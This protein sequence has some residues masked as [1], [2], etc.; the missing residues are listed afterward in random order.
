MSIK[1]FFKKAVRRLIRKI[2][3]C[4]RR[5]IVNKNHITL[6]EVFFNNF[7]PKCSFL[8][9]LNNKDHYI[10]ELNRLSVCSSIINSADKIC[11]HEFNLLGSGNK[12][13]GEKL[14]WNE[15]FKTWFKWNNKFYKDIKIVDLYNNADVKVPWELSRFQHLFTLGKAYWITNDENYALEF[16]EEVQHWIEKNPV[17]LSVNWACTMDAAIRAV[18]L[19]CGYFF[20]IESSSIDNNFRIKF[21][22]LLYTHGRFIY[23][24]LENEEENRNN[25]YLSDLAGLIW[26]GIFFENFNIKNS[27]KYNNPKH[28]LKFGLSEFENEMKKQVNEDG[29]DYEGS[30]AYHRL[31]T[32]IFLITT[33]LCNKNN[34]IFSKEYITKL[35]KMCEF[36]MNIDKPNGLS[37]IIGD[38]DDGRLLIL[39]NYGQWDRRDFTHVLAIAGEYFGRDDFRILGK[40]HGEDALWV[41]GS[42]KEICK[43]PELTSKAYH[44]GGYYILRNSRFY[45]IV[46]CGELSLRGEGGHSHNDQLSI[47]INVD[48]ENFIIDPGVYVYTADY[49]MRNLFRSTK[50]HNTLFIDNCEQNDFNEY[51]LFYMREQTFAQCKLFNGTNFSGQHY[52]Y[53]EKCGVIHERQINLE[54]NQVNIIDNIIGNKVSNAFINF[55][56]D[57]GVE[58]EEKHNQI[59][60]SKNGRNISLDFRSKYSIED[61]FVSY[62]YGQKLRSKKIIF[63]V[64]NNISSI[65]IKIV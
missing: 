46:R 35:E 43:E 57:Y 52:G 2:Y 29:T 41:M 60:L 9:N 4:Y 64:A 15:D 14:P 17:E 61:S 62:G 10:S 25:H 59:V 27:E 39:S 12:Y 33:V 16:K 65:K 56:L 5:I 18:N 6:E 50:M 49:K 8:Y 11:S 45:C 19:I 1:L 30:T 24:N 47:E 38:A 22:N 42:Y 55:Q 48:G 44:R 31:V 51:N 32:E 21:N 28:W 37:P 36:I 26:L 54:N 58:V 23:K 40:H 34:I 53:K 7:N 63:T 3:Y 13:L 20:F